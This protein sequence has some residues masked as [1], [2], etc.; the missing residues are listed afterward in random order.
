MKLEDGVKA[1]EN[2][3]EWELAVEGAL[4]I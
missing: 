4:E 1:T 3:D 2:P